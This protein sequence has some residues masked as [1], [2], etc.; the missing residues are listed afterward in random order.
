M[1]L[2]PPHILLVSERAYHHHTRAEAGVN[3]LIGYHLDLVPKQG[4]FER[5]PHKLLVAPI[6]WVH[7]HGNTRTQKLRSRGG[8]VH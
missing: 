2:P 8:Y 7:S 5:L 4:N 1:L 6:I 3:C